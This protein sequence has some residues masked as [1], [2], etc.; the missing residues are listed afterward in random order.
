MLKIKQKNIGVSLQ[1][2]SNSLL[3]F[4][5]VSHWPRNG[6][7]GKAINQR[8]PGTCLSLHPQHCSFQCLHQN[9]LRLRDYKIKYI[10][11]NYTPPLGIRTVTSIRHRKMFLFCC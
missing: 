8:A 10:I 5:T 7:A 3:Q 1:V 2:L 4:E 11:I 9:Q 6:Q